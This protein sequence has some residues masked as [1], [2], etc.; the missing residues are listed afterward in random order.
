MNLLTELCQYKLDMQTCQNSGIYILFVSVSWLFFLFVFFF[1]FPLIS[2]VTENIAELELGDPW[3]W[4]PRCPVVDGGG[5]GSGHTVGAPASWN[6]VEGK[7]Q[8]NLSLNAL[9]LSTRV[10]VLQRHCWLV[11]GQKRGPGVEGT[12]LCCAA[13]VIGLDLSLGL[14]SLTD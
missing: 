10:P 5:W 12:L 11:R 13:G 9:V 7:P 14:N 8:Q 4:G 2:W 1:I 6:R 3:G